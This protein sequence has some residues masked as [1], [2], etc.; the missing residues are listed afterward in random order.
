MTDQS[1]S[2]I[3]IHVDSIDHHELITV[4]QDTFRVQE[5]LSHLVDLLEVE[6]VNLCTV[7]EH[8]SQVCNS[9]AVAGY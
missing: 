1:I 5:C 8:L 9:K 4:E 2:N 3:L 7:K 6:V